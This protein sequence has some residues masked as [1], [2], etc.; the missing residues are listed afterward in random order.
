MNRWADWWNQGLRDLAHAEHALE[1]GDFEWAAFAALQCA[2]K[3]L[4]ALILHRGAEPLGH[5]ITILAETLPADLRLQREIL[6]AANRLDKHYIPARYP[7]K[8]GTK[9]VPG[10]SF[11][12]FEGWEKH[13]G[14]RP[15][16]FGRISLPNCT[17]NNLAVASLP[18]KRPRAVALRMRS[19]S[20]LSAAIFSK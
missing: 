3:A 11:P 15:G 1:D 14:L 19:A 7:N 18:K 12:D 8:I 20:D 17:S 2:E 16:F 5:S 13:L 4:K 10:Y 6:E 9:S